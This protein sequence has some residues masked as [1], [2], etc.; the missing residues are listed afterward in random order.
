MINLNFQR[1]MKSVNTML[2]IRYTTVSPFT[3]A[4]LLCLLIRLY[5]FHH[6]DTQSIVLI[7]HTVLLLRF[8]FH[9]DNY[10]TKFNKLL[11]IR[12]NTYEAFYV[13]LRA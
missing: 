6:T 12:K 10:G 9:I 1:A 13:M 7:L 5:M 11:N 4:S 3:D 2:S 8:Q